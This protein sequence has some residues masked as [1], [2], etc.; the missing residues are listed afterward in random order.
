MPFKTAGVIQPWQVYAQI[1]ELMILDL[2]IASP[3]LVVS[4]NN[5]PMQ[6]RVVGCVF[7]FFS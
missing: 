1:P 2:Y 5:R 7:F 4:W 3:V 6:H